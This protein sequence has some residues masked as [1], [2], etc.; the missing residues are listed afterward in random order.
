MAF[1]PLVSVY[2]VIVPAFLCF[3]AEEVNGVVFNPADV[4][5]FRDMLQA[6]GLIPAQGK[7]IERD[8]ATDRVSKPLSQESRF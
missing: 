2:L 6:V 8:L 4:L 7:D 5:F 3:V 1:N